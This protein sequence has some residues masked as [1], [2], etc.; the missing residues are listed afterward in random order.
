MAEIIGEKIILRS[1]TEADTPNIIRWRNSPEVMKYFIIQ[2]PL[3]VEG[4]T[5]WLRTKVASGEVVQFVIY[6]KETDRPIG[7]V[8][9]R[10]VNQT[11][12]K[13][14]YGIFLGEDDVRGKGYGTE[15]AE[16]IVDYA[17]KELKLHKIYLEVLAD[18]IRAQKSYAKVG[19]EK[20]AYQRDEV[21]I[22]GAYKDLIL[23]AII[24]KRE[25]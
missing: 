22:N 10:D 24:N 4:H 6:E 14:E 7:S 8:Y 5:N 12:K 21:R 25:E 15:A 2:Q 1:I 3:T 16:L 18:N 17:F 13:A 11:H 20:E 23:M 19:F 9:L